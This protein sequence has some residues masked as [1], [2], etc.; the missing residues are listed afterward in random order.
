MRV[1][2]SEWYPQVSAE[3]TL[4]A[5]IR[6]HQQGAVVADERTLVSSWI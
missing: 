4:P 5:T 3:L 2:L 1:V 6:Q